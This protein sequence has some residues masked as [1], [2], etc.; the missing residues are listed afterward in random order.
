MSATLAE[1]SFSLNGVNLTGAH[2]VGR[3]GAFLV[4]L[5]FL[6]TFAFIRT[7]ARLIR[8]EVS[9]WPGNVETSSGL[10][11][12]HLFWGILL[13]IVAGFVSFIGLPS[14]WWQ[15]T[16]VAFGIGMGLTL[17]EY[18]LWL[19]LDD[20]YWKDQG[21]SSIDAVVIAL[22][23]AG[24]VALGARPFT[25]DSGGDLLATVAGTAVDVAFALITL[26][27]KRLFLGALAFFLA[28]VGV[29][30]T[31]RIGKPNSYWARRFYTEQTARGRR[32]ME[33]SRK[34]FPPDRWTKKLGQRLQDAIGGAPTPELAPAEATPKPPSS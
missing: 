29:W 24:L 6:L 4:V 2:A 32:K 5:G 27:K 12:H 22:L 19:Y 28:P 34:R 10:H 33:R 26:A 1:V 8:M 3:G 23:L 21:R 16:A 14:P 20:V 7:S 11:I 17:D 25:V 9:W 15:I 30:C 31:C 18:A 13:L